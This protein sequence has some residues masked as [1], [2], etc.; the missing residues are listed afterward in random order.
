MNNIKNA[1]NSSFINGGNRGNWLKCKLGFDG[2][3]GR[4]LYLKILNC[5]GNNIFW[6]SDNDSFKSKWAIA[7]KYQQ[8]GAW[9]QCSS[10]CFSKT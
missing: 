2:Y 7:I 5:T 1:E 9:V 3:P 6:D 4:R 8:H 10:Q